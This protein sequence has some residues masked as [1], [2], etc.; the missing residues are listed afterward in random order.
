M[1]GDDEKR[2]ERTKNSALLAP[3]RQLAKD[4]DIARATWVL[5]GLCVGASGENFTDA[6]VVIVEMMCSLVIWLLIPP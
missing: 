2:G 4:P 5:V 6:G 1:L 3:N